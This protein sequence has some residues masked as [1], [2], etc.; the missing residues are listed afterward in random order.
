MGADE[1]GLALSVWTAM[2][3]PA[4]IVAVGIG[5]DFAGQATAAQEARAIAAEAARAAT[6]EIVIGPAG[7]VL[8]VPRA[9]AAALNFASVSGHRASVTMS[10]G[11][12]ATVRIESSYQTVFLGL[13]GIHEIGFDVTGSARAVRTFDGAES[14]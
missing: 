12:T 3:L 9:K 6:H 10:G 8:D 4:F 11:S 13:I 5:V 7:P 1:R 14:G 2:V